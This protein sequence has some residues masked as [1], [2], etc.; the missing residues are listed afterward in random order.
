MIIV[1][2]FG[3]MG[4]QMFQYAAARRLAYV[5]RTELKLDISH[6]NSQNLRRYSLNCFNIRND[7]ATL[8][9][10]N[11]FKPWEM[12]LTRR[13][14]S[15]IKRCFSKPDHFF[16]KENFFYFNPEILNLQN[17]V[18]L[19]GYWQSE[20]YFKN[21]EEIIRREFTI[22]VPQNGKNRKLAKMITSS[23]SVSLHI[24]RGDYATN[25]SVNKKHGICKLDYYQRCVQMIT[26][27]SD[28]P[29]FFLF[30]DDPEWVKTNFKID[31]PLNIID[32]NNADCAFED[33]RL[34]SQ[35]KHNIIANSTLS[36]WGA[37][38]NSNPNKIVFAPKKWFKA[39][40]LKDKDLI[41][42][43]WSR[44]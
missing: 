26:Q 42:S 27:K 37:W 9:E 13:I 10:I 33:L 44:V 8:G 11:K 21:I 4:N 38:L 23:E 32:H 5:H 14:F 19:S 36:W 29:R 39:G 43:T 30:S 7:F 34:M 20:E 17:E 1:K 2:L 15:K 3:G 31:Y 16:V 41:P 12:K 40:D 35:C 22:K 6:F 28:N 18:Y 25:L 24:R